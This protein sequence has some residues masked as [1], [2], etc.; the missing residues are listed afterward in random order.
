[1]AFYLRK[2]VRA[3]PF[4]F[5]LSKSGVGVSAGVRGLRFGT[6]PRGNYVHMGRGGLYYRQ[7]LG[8]SGAKAK[9]SA[10]PQPVRPDSTHPAPSLDQETEL[11]E[12]ESGSVLDMVDVTASDLL[13]EINEKQARSSLWPAVAVVFAVVVGVGIQQ[14]Q[15]QEILAVGALVAIA[16]TAVMA[17]FDRRRKMVVLLF[18]LESDAE[19]AYRRV[20]DAFDE[21]N[22]AHRKWHVEAEGDVLDPKYQAGATVVVTRKHISL[23]SNPPNNIKTNIS[24]PIIPVGRQKLC[25]F[26][27][28]LLVFDKAK[29]GAVPYDELSID[30]TPGRFIEEERPP[31]DAEQVDTTWQY[32]NKRGGPDRRFNN[33]PELPVML[34]DNVRFRSRSGLNEY[35]QVSHVGVAEQ[36][37]KQVKKLNA[38]AG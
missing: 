8:G 13:K 38:T 6:G 10:R 32:V 16:I 5:N 36:F 15:P 2:S 20:H 37:A 33:N 1:M 12:I 31:K 9:P 19:Q 34:Y 29:V 27:D 35:I 17:I 24:V 28:R 11:R 22:K 21:L 25:F 14:Q 4:R 3:G 7:S 18:D 23:S 26:P 30:V